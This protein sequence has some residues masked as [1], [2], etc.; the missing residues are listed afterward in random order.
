MLSVEA[1]LLSVVATLLGT[2]IGVAFAAVGV[3]SLVQPAIDGAECRPPVG[4]ALG[5]RTRV[6]TR[7]AAVRRT[8]G[9]AC[10]AGHTS[11]RT[12]IGVGGGSLRFPRE[13]LAE[14]AAARGH[15]QGRHGQVDGRGRRWRWPSRHTGKNVLL[16]EVEGR[17]GIARMFDVDPLP[18]EERRI[19]TGFP[20]PTGGRASSTPCTSTP[21]PRCWSTCRCTTGSAA[22]ARRSTGSA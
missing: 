7:R 16:C 6:G 14:G 13:R 20:T 3:R 22:P 17:Q 21:R 19:A 8:P 9:P 4:S 1:L 10:G 18:Y 2:T 12:R 15:R 11:R 5:G